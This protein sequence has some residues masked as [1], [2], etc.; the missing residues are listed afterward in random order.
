MARI[1]KQILRI[2]ASQENDSKKQMLKQGSS[3]LKKDRTLAILESSK[4]S[5]EPFSGKDGVY[6]YLPKNNLF[7]GSKSQLKLPDP[8]IYQSWKNYIEHSNT[9][10]HEVPF[11]MTFQCLCES[12][13]NRNKQTFKVVMSAVPQLHALDTCLDEP[14]MEGKPRLDHILELIFEIQISNHFRSIKEKVKLIKCLRES[15]QAAYSS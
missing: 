10:G 7:D 5:S 12:V 15:Q 13:G 6:N 3:D 2:A 8:V 11:L 4:D 1:K 9:Q 14:P